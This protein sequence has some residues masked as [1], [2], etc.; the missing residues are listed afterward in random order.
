MKGNG[1]KPHR[2]DSEAKQNLEKND[3][4]HSATREKYLRDRTNKKK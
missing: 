1:N 4:K 2:I 3:T